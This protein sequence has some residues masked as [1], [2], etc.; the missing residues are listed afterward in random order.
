MVD[1]IMDG[2]VR[3]NSKMR[4]DKLMHHHLTHQFSPHTERLFLQKKKKKQ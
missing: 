2:V 3:K 1:M 4:R